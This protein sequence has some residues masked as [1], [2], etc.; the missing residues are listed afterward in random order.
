MALVSGERLRAHL[1][2]IGAPP[3]AVA[4]ADDAA[5]TAS[6]YVAAFCTRLRVG[7]P[8]PPV[9]ERVTLALGV[10]VALNPSAL[11]QASAEGQSVAYPPIGFTFLESVLLHRYRRRSA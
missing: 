9:V 2:A 6:T 11:R 1:R 10:R 5:D 7:D 4:V 8:V 3:Q